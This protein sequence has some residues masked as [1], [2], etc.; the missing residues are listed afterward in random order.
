MKIKNKDTGKF[1]DLNKIKSE[2]I[3]KA[4]NDYKKLDKSKS[5]LKDL[6]ERVELLE[7]ILLD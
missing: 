3:K 2:R 5:T 6:K 4:K 1:E 7:N